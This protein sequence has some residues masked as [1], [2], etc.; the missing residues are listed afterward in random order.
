VSSVGSALTY[1]RA[2]VFFLGNA[3]PSIAFGTW[4]LGNGQ[5]PIDKV[6]QAISVG[7]NHI[8]TSNFAH[9]VLLV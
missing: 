5:N 4:L 1:R 7:F 2:S 8:G 6:E 3:I 9:L